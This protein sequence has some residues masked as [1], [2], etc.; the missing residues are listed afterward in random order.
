MQ[1]I[2]LLLHSPEPRARDGPGASL[3][4]ANA[5]AGAG[6]EQRD[7]APLTEPPL[8]HRLAHTPGALLEVKPER[9][10]W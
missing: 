2:R 8:R 6:W 10:G 9:R 4:G 7:T 3:P 1:Q 5:S